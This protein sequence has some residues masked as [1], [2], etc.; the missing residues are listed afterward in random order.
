[1]KRLA[2]F[3]DQ[4]STAGREVYGDFARSTGWQLEENSWDADAAVIWSI[5]W[6]GRM[7]KNQSVYEHY[8]KQRKPVI[9]V[10]TGVL[11]R[12]Q[13]YK[14]CVNE[15]DRYGDYWHVKD[16][17]DPDRV[18]RMLG[19][20]NQIQ[21]GDK[22][23]ICAQNP[24]SQNWKKYRNEDSNE[25][26]EDWVRSKVAWAKCWTD[27]PIEIR[28]HP[29]YSLRLPDLQDLIVNP[30]YTVKDD[31]DLVRVFEDCFMVINYNSYPGI[32]A[33]LHGLHTSVHHSS[34]AALNKTDDIHD[35]IH[36]EW[37]DFIARTEFT[38]DEI[39]RGFA[40]DKIRYAVDLPQD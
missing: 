9:I 26:M 40:W 28:P 12:N 25:T 13:T 21:G 35:D 27:R 18:Y 39:R 29:R 15:T 11:K 30:Q 33:R 17:S 37:L 2:V 1:V 22:I 31:T 36:D 14:V 10:E 23:L 7:A 3:P 4:V 8:R 24:N 38:H 34:L 32:Q 5:L 16:D 19:H 20:I 6:N